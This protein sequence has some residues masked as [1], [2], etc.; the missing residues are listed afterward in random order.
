[1]NYSFCRSRSGRR[2]RGGDNGT[3]QGEGKESKEK[4]WSVSG[5]KVVPPTNPTPP[6]NLGDNLSNFFYDTRLR[7]E[8]FR[9]TAEQ[10]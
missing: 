9:L 8:G 6:R 4:D 2:G 5:L 1:M 7:E 10:V 3:G